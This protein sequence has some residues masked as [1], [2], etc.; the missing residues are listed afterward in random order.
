MKR[1]PILGCTVDIER[2]AIAMQYQRSTDDSRAYRYT[3]RLSDAIHLLSKINFTEER[4][5]YGCGNAFYTWTQ[6]FKEVVFCRV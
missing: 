4:C 3:M 6:H 2:T 5:K 1:D